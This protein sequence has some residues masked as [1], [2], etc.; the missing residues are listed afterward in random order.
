MPC[1]SGKKQQETAARAAAHRVAEAAV[2]EFDEEEEEPAPQPEPG[3]FAIA[4]APRRAPRA[5]ARDKEVLPE[6]SATIAVCALTPW[7]VW[8]QRT[9]PGV[10]CLGARLPAWRRRRLRLSRAIVL[11]ALRGRAVELMKQHS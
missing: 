4:P 7:V 9:W 1:N 6:G 2:A 10:L 3:P 8:T 5:L 11:S